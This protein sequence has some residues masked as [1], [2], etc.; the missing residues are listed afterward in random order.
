MLRKDGLNG[1]KETC[2]ALCVPKEHCKPGLEVNVII[3]SGGIMIGGEV[4][5]WN[6]LEVAKLRARGCEI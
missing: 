6:E 2:M 1:L 5:E 3:G 4:I